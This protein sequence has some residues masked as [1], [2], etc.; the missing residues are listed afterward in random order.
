MTPSLNGPGGFDPKASYIEALIQREKVKHPN[1]SESDVNALR[2]YYSRMDI[3]QLSKL[4]SPKQDPVDMSQLRANFEKT[5]AELFPEEKPKGIARV[6]GAIVKATP[7]AVGVGLI[8]TG[9]VVTGGTVLGS[10]AGA[11]SAM[12]PIA[13]GA[14]AGVGLVMMAFGHQS[15]KKEAGG[16]PVQPLPG[17][18]MTQTQIVNIDIEALVNQLASGFQAI[19]D[20][21][22]HNHQELLDKITSENQALKDLMQKVI[23]LL[24]HIDSMSTQQ[25]ALTGS[26]YTAL[27]NLNNDVNGNHDELIALLNNLLDK[28]DEMSNQDAANYAAII[29]LLNN[30]HETQNGMASTLEQILAKLNDLEGQF[31]QL[32]SMLA[33][34]LA[35][36]VTMD[37]HQQN[38][39]IG[40]IEGI[41]GNTQLL[42]QILNAING[43]AGQNTN[44]QASLQQII[45]ILMGMGVDIN[46]ILQGVNNNS[47]F[48][49]EILAAIQD[50]HGTVQ[51]NAQTIIALM[52]QNNA[53]CQEIL[54]AIR[55]LDANM[56]AYYLGLLGQ[57]QANG[58]T[59][60]QILEWVQ[61]NGQILEGILAEIQSL[62][63]DVNTNAQNI[64]QQL[65]VNNQLLDQIKALINS[66]GNQH[67]QYLNQI[68]A[69]LMHMGGDLQ[70]LI[71]AV[72]ANHDVLVSIL[73]KMNSLGNTIT[74]LLTEVLAKLD[75]ID[76]HNQAGF[77]AVIDKIDQ[78]DANLRAKFIAVLNKLDQLDAH[79]QA[80]II[81]ILQRID[82]LNANVLNIIEKL[83]DIEVLMQQGKDYTQQL[84]TL[85]QGMGTLQEGQAQ[86]LQVLF[87][88]LAAI[89]SGS[90]GGANVDLTNIENLLTQILQQEQTNGN[91]L[92][93]MNYNIA[94]IN[95]TVS[96]LVQLMQTVITNQ[97]T[98]NTWLELIF[99]KIPTDPGSCNCDCERII[100]LLIQISVQLQSGDWNHEGIIEEFDDLLS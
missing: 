19:I 62:H 21:L 80:G 65:V 14:L 76:Q 17:I 40:I 22:N 29:A 6:A 34:I 37:E 89:P 3:D 74:N 86:Q 75:K 58:M 82:D 96:G 48:L 94:L 72:N 16:P 73:G 84:N 31:P 55:N 63:G 79:Q 27:L 61:N 38:A 49:Q 47:A 93:N 10:L 13:K 81:A 60:Q 9:A 26:I 45:A 28:V 51:H 24:T 64:L 4:L 32:Q 95:S 78:L 1:M 46:A 35:Q 88:I 30:M 91:T 18:N 44:M 98:Q 69:Q 41:A 97:D 70:A 83:V 68:L 15:C 39:A 57:L 99:N 5:S 59:E 67:S 2:Q 12:P 92:N 33:A 20:T 7:K 71:A 43:I 53:L 56:Q 100:E 52:T 66:F 85:I 25:L 77:L 11:F 90:G 23:D 87:E 8:A 50:L 42:Q 36:L 54:E